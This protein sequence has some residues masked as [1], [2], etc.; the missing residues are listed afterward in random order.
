MRVYYPR[1]LS[2]AV[3]QQ[4]DELLR[5]RGIDIRVS[6]CSD[7]VPD[8]DVLIEGR[9]SKE[10]LEASKSLRIVITPF[11]GVPKATLEL[12]E[13]FQN[14]SLHNLHH[15][16]ADTAETALAL[17]LACS[18]R[19]VPLDQQMRKG[20]W[21]ARYTSSRSL[22]LE[23]RTVVVLGYGH[24]GQRIARACEAMGMEVIAT[25]KSA[26]A[27]RFDRGVTIHPAGDMIRLLPEANV[28]IVA[29]PETSETHGLIGKAELDAM[30]NGS[31]LI[32]VARGDIVDEE[33]LYQAL[34]SGKLDS[35]G[36]D[37]WY[38]YP[39]DKGG[40]GVPSYFVMPE[41][42]NHTFPS[43]FPFHELD[44]VVMSPHRAGVSADTEAMRIIHLAHML[45]QFAN[46]EPVANKVDL[47]RG[48]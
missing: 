7:D 18:R 36:L 9:P 39:T 6:T 43:R 16:A 24:I 26:D 42:A 15:N 11:A 32:N 10:M 1:P 41:S 31:I 17:L 5:R 13:Q 47:R 33:A 22:L 34:N 28:L 12:L 27:I 23:G 38:Q 25:R 40:K 37:V 46:G 30:P 4:L 19:V 21:S 44:N 48:Y 20:D 2:E 45:E 14:I 3:A 35:A 8:Y 29:L